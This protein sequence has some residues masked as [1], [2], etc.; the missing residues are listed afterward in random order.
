MVVDVGDAGP[1]A[2]GVGVVEDDDVLVGGGASVDDPFG[3]SGVVTSL[4]A[5]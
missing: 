5:W 3:F 2:V 1:D 4:F